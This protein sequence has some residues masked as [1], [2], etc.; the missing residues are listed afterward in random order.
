MSQ[1]HTSAP[2]GPSKRQDLTQLVLMRRLVFIA[3]ILGLYLQVPL[4]VPYGLFL[5][6]S[7]VLSVLAFP[8]PA[9]YHPMIFFLVFGTVMLLITSFAHPSDLGNQTSSTILLWLS[10][11][12]SLAVGTQLRRLGKRRMAKW[13]WWITVAIIIGALLERLGPLRPISDGIRS[14]LYPA[15]ILYD[16]E[17]RDLANHG[18]VRPKLLTSEPSHLGKF[19]AT[20]ITVAAA[21]DSRRIKHLVVNVA[22]Y[23]VIASPVILIAVGV[24]VL[25]IL[26]ARG[27]RRSFRSPF[28]MLP[29]VLTL[30]LVAVYVYQIATVRLSGN[31]GGI[32]PSTYQRIVQPYLVMMMSLEQRPL[33]GYGL[34]SQALLERFFHITFVSSYAPEF[35]RNESYEIARS[36]G[37][38]HFG[39]VAQFGV[40]GSA[41]WLFC[42]EQ[43]RR[44]FSAAAIPFWAFYVGYGFFTAAVNTPLLIAPLC[45]VA[46]GLSA[47][48][49]RT[50]A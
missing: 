40:L 45:L 39:M 42:I 11:F 23:M 3:A 25:M 47:D 32:E 12:A 44:S 21:L 5:L 36:F 50:L 13:F 33:F 6:P 31:G 37:N 34:G 22:G 17:A 27:W 14:A 29:A 43:I 20:F 19:F 16:G 8:G 35:F 15:S 9:P 2:Y 4:G 7:L 30:A 1:T 28:I 10:I 38:I 46:F 49:R 26:Q 24:I 48:R 18:F 41:I